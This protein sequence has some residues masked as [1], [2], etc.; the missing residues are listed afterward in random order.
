MSMPI[1]ALA[2]Y[3]TARN[4]HG[5]KERSHSVAL[6]VV[7]HSLT[8][9]LLDRKPRLGAVKCLNLTL[10]VT[11]QH[12]CMLRWREVKT[13]NVFQLLLKVLIIGKLKAFDSMWLQSV[14][15]P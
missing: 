13:Y 11:R 2:D 3:S 10:L 8:S 15:R 12:D 1:H 9:T 5:G 7:S 4:V 6:V 14:C